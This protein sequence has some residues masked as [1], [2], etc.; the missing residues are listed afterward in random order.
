M[1]GGLFRVSKDV[2]PFILAGGHPLKYEGLNVVGLRR[3]D[4][5][6]D[7]IKALKDAYRLIYQSDLLRN[8]ALEKIEEDIRHPEVKA[9]VDFYRNSQRGVI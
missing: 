9:V 2:P 6:N 7:A 4:F 8:Q 3:R 5:T 1:V